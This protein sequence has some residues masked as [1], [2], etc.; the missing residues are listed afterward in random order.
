MHPAP[1]HHESDAARLEAHLAAYSFVTL[2]V[3]A[4]V[5]PVVAGKR[6]QMTPARAGKA[7]AAQ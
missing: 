7:L 3:A 1:Y 5:R 2:C 6:D 4:D